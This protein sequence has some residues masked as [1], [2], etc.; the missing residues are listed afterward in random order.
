M[1]YNVFSGTLNPTHFTSLRVVVGRSYDVD[2]ASPRL[3][4]HIISRADR[5]AIRPASTTCHVGVEI[6]RRTW[7][8]RWRCSRRYRSLTATTWW[9][10]RRPSTCD[11]LTAVNS[12]RRRTVR[13]STYMTAVVQCRSTTTSS[14]HHTPMS[15]G[16]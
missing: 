4:C 6:R 5:Q 3:T 9:T 14:S 13:T 10:V 2:L 15:R 1:T 16:K 12:A 8:A 7:R 11:R